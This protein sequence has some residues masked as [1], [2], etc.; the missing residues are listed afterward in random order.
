METLTENGENAF[1][2][3]LNANVDLFVSLVRSIDTEKLIDLLEKSWIQDPELTLK[4]IL[5]ARDRHALGEKFLSFRM[6]VWLMYRFENLYNLNFKE[7]V[8]LGKLH[9]LLRLIRAKQVLKKNYNVEVDYFIQLLKDGEHSAFK[10]APSEGKEFND[11]AKIIRQR[12]NMNAKQYRQFLTAG[13]KQKFL[14]EPVLCQRLD[15]VVDFSK[16]PSQAMFKYKKTFQK[17]ENHLNQQYKAYLEKVV[18]GEAK[19]N[20]GTLMP[21][22][23]INQ[24]DETS[25][26][27]WDDLIKRLENGNTDYLKN[28]IAV[29]DVSSSMEIRVG[30]GVTAMDVAISLSLV[31]S[32]LSSH[33]KIITFSQ[34]PTLIEIPNNKNLTEKFSII[35]SAPW[36]MNTDI[37]AVFKLILEKEIDVKNIF[38]FTDMQFDKAVT[39][40]ANY[41]TSYDKCCELFNQAG[42]KIPQVIYWN[43]AAAQSALPVQNGQ[44]GTALL[45]GFSTTFFK[46]FLDGDDI[47]P[48]G[49]MKKIINQYNI[50]YQEEK[51]ELGF[52]PWSEIEPR[53]KSKEKRR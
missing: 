43:V 2:T 39:N 24:T 44:A 35:R 50:V 31:L 37:F 36:G 18:K 16:V 46:S 51:R 5:Y 3:T 23:L 22:Q 4:I 11:I 32:E 13:R 52:I 45:S 49:I 14:I 34:T 28:S 41:Q 20:S 1:S 53:L 12:L 33:R 47:T 21:Y 40:A 15:Q 17:E 27:L 19:I 30:V 26:I 38:I 10:W 48:V 7:F 42:K 9:D 25:N 6:M 8:K 29:C